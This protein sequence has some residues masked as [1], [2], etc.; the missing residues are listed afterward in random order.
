M[1]SHSDASVGQENALLQRQSDCE[2]KTGKLSV[3]DSE[4]LI[5]D[6]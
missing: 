4:T 1:L 3:V 2:Y 6:R 5:K